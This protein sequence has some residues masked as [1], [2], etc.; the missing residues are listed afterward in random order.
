MSDERLVEIWTDGDIVTARSEGRAIA[1]ELGFSATETTLIS[2][3]ISELARNILEYAGN[4]RILIRVEEAGGRRGIVIEASD[5][6]PGIDDIERAVQ[7]GYSTGGNL[8]LGLPGARRLLDELEV[9]SEP[10]KGTL[11]VGKKWRP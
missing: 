9:S 3:A 1:L 6:G 8:G 4:G 2:T 5:E 7:D 10:G 11:V